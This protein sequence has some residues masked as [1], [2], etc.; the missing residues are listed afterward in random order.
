MWILYYYIPYQLQVYVCVYKYV[1]IFLCSNMSQVNVKIERKR[2]FFITKTPTPSQIFW[3]TNNKGTILNEVQKG[4]RAI[5]YERPKFSSL[6]DL[7][8]S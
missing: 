4:F 2:I 3:I 7:W 5:V 6:H 8:L 1:C